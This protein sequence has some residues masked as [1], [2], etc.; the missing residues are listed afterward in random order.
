MIGE[1]EKPGNSITPV[2]LERLRPARG[3]ALPP[4]TCSAGGFRLRTS[5]TYNDDAR[6]LDRV[7]LFDI[8]HQAGFDREQCVNL[9]S[10]EPLIGRHHWTAHCFGTR[11]F[12]R[13]A[14]RLAHDHRLTFPS[15]RRSYAARSWLS[16][17][18][19]ADAPSSSWPA[20]RA[21]EKNSR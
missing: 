21:S 12:S 17:Q 13:F 9:G 15:S 14:V 5:S 1:A 8:S 20:Q 19:A 7:A 10:P 3:T 4:V 6:G 16:S 2:R 18:R 11:G